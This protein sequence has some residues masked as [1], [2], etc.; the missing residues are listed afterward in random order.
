MNTP[1]KVMIGIGVAASMIGLAIALGKPKPKIF[2]ITP[3]LLGTFTPPAPNPDRAKPSKDGAGAP[4]ALE[5]FGPPGVPYHL[6]KQKAGNLLEITD[7]RAMLEL[8]LGMAKDMKVGK[9]GS[10]RTALTKIAKQLAKGGINR[11]S[12]EQ[13]PSFGSIPFA[14]VTNFL[15][16]VPWGTVAPMAKAWLEQNGLA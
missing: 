8:V 6:F 1:T 5:G 13:L 7:A 9:F 12:F 16:N 15:K 10:A 14:E 2:Q 11:V 3:N 4:A